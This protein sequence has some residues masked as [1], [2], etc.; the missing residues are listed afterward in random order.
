M[1]VSTFLRDTVLSAFAEYRLMFDEATSPPKNR[2]FVWSPKM[3]RV[4]GFSERTTFLFFLMKEEN[5][6]FI[7]VF[8][9]TYPEAVVVAKSQANYVI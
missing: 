9:V 2:V 6:G 7:A 3:C 1:Y 4:T 5:V 8:I